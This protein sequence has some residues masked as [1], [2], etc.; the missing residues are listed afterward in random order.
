MVR[1]RAATATMAWDELRWRAE[2]N[3]REAFRAMAR[4]AAEGAVLEVDSACHVA[5]GIPN[6]FFNPVFLQR[7][8]DDV[9]G[10]QRRA[11]AF[12]QARGGLPWT[13]VQLQG[14]G[15]E[16]MVS[17]ARLLDAGMVAAGAVP[18]LVRSTQRGD[19]WPRVQRDISIER[20][21]C[22]DTLNDHRETLAEAF[23][24]PG[25]VTEMLI[26]DIPPPVLRL[27]VA[28]RDGQAVGTA[29]LFEAGGIGGIYNLGTHPGCRRRGV[30][31]ALLRH[32][33]DEACW[34]CGLSECVVQASRMSLPLFLSAG[35]EPAA[36]CAR[37]A[38]VQHLPPGEARK[39]SA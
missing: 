33:L 21:D 15:E 12:Y 20:V 16:P 9:E 1:R 13:L 23:G 2:E 27:Y 30:A 3:L 6:A 25:Y 17:P 18:M 22:A 7:P 31:T 26:P 4:Y 5:T 37:Y 35:F 32:A 29:G 14:E 8:P 34:E 39:R 36:T 38:E 19:S 11:R 28:Y 24:L 10:F